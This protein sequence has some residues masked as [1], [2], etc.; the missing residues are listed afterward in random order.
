M[1][2]PLARRALGRTGL[3]VTVLGFGTAPLGNLFEHLDEAT[4]HAATLEA[5]DRGINLF[6]TAP[7]YGHGLAELRVGAALREGQ[8]RHPREDLVVSTKVGRWMDPHEKPVG[9]MTP[10][11]PKDASAD[12]AAVI[13]P[14]FVGALPHRAVFDYSHDGTLR[15]I[16][17]SLLRLGL[18][19]LDIVLIH[20]VDVWTHGAASI[21][22]RFKE[23]MDG[24]YRALERLRSEGV[25]KAIGVGVNESEMCERFA[26]AG[27]F[28][29]MLL[30]GRY[31]LLEQPALDTFLP[32]AQAKGIAI[33]LGG[34]F[35][36]GI[37]ATGAVP[38]ARYN[39][40]E[41]PP[42]VM[43]R[44]QR[45]E[46]V[47]AA[48]GVKLVDAA[49]QF[50]LAHPAV[51][52]LVLGAVTPIEVQRNLVS[53]R[54]SVPAAFWSAMREQGLLAANAPTPAGPAA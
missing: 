27:D 41:A 21:D 31:S 46:A 32:L 5:L 17:Q 51:S 49:L 34:V 29:T 52:S 44:V 26:H 43:A 38:G 16:E 47:C 7:L 35:N 45:I 40:R 13:S 10:A 33:L 25:V 2:G 11:K 9:A 12:T 50:A 36:S 28:D 6:D 14:G 18:D 15:S 3:E 24:A 8:H 20:D 19:R 53:L 23:A 1:T 54:A 4:A 48:H 22:A 39:Y 42:E 37:L 30:A